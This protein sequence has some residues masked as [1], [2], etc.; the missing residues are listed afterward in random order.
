M[1]CDPNSN[2]SAQEL[3]RSAR[4]EVAPETFT[5]ISLSREHFVRLLDNSDL[6]PRVGAPFTIFYDRYEV[7][8]ML[9]QADFKTLEHAV[10]D[11]RVEGG[12]RMLTFDLV[13]EFSVVGFIAEVSRILAEAKISI[14]PLSAFSRDHVLIKQEHMA[15]A[16]KAL[17][18]YAGDL[19]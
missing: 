15:A 18:E 9:D 3:L 19:C 6:S 17:G 13:L 10:G 16:L 12:F 7:T 1:S 4:V 5:L 8:L 2:I 11:A 14:L